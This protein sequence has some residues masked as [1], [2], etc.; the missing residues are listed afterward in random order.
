VAE[1]FVEAQG[2]LFAKPV[3]V[4]EIRRLLG[5]GCLEAA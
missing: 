3:S 4:R 1:G 5:A 2:Y